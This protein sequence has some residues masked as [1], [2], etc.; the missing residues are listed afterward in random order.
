MTKDQ[1]LNPFSGAAACAAVVLAGGLIVAAANP[2]AAGNGQLPGSSLH[3]DAMN[4][5]GNVQD[6]GR[7]RPDFDVQVAMGELIAATADD[8]KTPDDAGK[9]AEDAHEALFA[10]KRFP[11]AA[12]C[13]SCHPKNYRDWAVSQHAYSQ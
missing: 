7:Y 11:S 2:A 6:F 9:S 12:T 3:R 5:H 8:K 1:I 10:E 4:V 13:G